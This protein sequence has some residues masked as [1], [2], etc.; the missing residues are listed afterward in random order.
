MVDNF[1]PQILRAAQ[2]VVQHGEEARDVGDWSWEPSIVVGTALFA[3]AYL[4]G[5]GPLRRRHQWADRVEPWRVALFLLGLLVF[6]L[7][8]VSPLDVLSDEYLFS[9]HMVQ[10]ILMAVIV[11]PL[12]LMGTPGWL[13]RP[14]IQVPH[15]LRIARMLTFPVVA[16][17]M[18]NLTFAFWHWPAL[19]DLAIMD[20]HV[21]VI[22][23]LSFAATAVLNWWP[24]LSP[25]PELPRLSYPLRVF[26]LFANCQPGVVLGALF[27][28]SRDVLYEA[29]IDAPRILG[30]SAHADQQLGGLIMWIPGNAIYLLALSIVF[31]R[32]IERGESAPRRE[33][34]REPANPAP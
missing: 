12:L 20:E 31:L 22:Q 21:H 23:H 2:T 1:G 25:L 26:Y 29:Y 5:I 28:F 18:F 32:W 24:V 13:L 11:P 10:H 27:V 7:A 16:F 9:A 30:L 3:A 33:V 19:Y 17:L 14:F 4:Y 34:G 15:V 8:L 6:L